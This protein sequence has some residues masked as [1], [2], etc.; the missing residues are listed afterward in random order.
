VSWKADMHGIL[1]VFRALS[2]RHRL[3]RRK[4]VRLAAAAEKKSAKPAWPNFF[5]GLAA[6]KKL[7]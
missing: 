3:H 7:G 4:N 1:E 2:S 6:E 5:Q